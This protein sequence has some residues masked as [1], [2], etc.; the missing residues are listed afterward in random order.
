[1]PLDERPKGDFGVAPG[2]EAVPQ[3]FEVGTKLM[4]VIEF[5][6]EGDD[7][8]PGFRSHRLRAP[9]EIDDFEPHGP[10]R[11]VRRFEYILLI[12]TAMAQTQR[13]F[14]NCAG[15]HAPVKMRIPRYSTQD[16]S[17]PSLPRQRHGRIRG[18]PKVHLTSPSQALGAHVSDPA[19][20]YR[21][22]RTQLNAVCRILPEESEKTMKEMEERN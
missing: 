20:F 7:E 1:V 5:P 11:N 17:P 12:R 16:P 21:F 13:R 6:I 14:P 2:M 18:H 4:V 22:P 10:E 15:I 9:F 3:R 8:I 19:A